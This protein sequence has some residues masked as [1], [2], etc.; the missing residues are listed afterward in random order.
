MIKGI[1]LACGVFLV[2]VVTGSFYG[3]AI[4]VRQNAVIIN[5]TDL[6]ADFS[7]AEAGLSQ[8]ASAI[9]SRRKRVG[10]ISTTTVTT[11]TVPTT[12]PTTTTTVPPP[13]PAAD[14]VVTFVQ[15]FD[16]P[17]SVTE[18]GSKTESK[19]GDWWVSS[20]AYF[21]SEG[22]VGKTVAGA[23]SAL[24]PWRVAYYLSNSLDTDNGYYPQ[25][26]FRLVQR[27]LWKDYTQEAYF[28]IT[29]DNLSVSPNRNASNGLFFFN[30]YADAFNLYYTGVRVDGY[31]VIKKKINGTYYTMAYKPFI[32]GGVYNRDTNPDMLPKNEWIGMR[33]EIRTLPDGSV[34]IKL[35][36]DKG[37][38]GTWT[39]VAEAV[40]NGTSFGGA[41][42]SLSGHVGIRTDFMDAE[43]DSYSVKTLR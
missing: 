18:A 6:D 10:R 5:D 36:A 37:K 40:D 33:S 32:A 31:A 3:K 25:N 9:S 7:Y 14:P 23:L 30:R 24:D 1:V 15:S 13:P 39:L 19:N 28:K 26:I 41:V 29:K 20:G 4:M 43:F 17:F 22:G 42:H 8:E 35:Y 2:I 16:S 11:P 21:I 34:S 38:T 27:S 12:T